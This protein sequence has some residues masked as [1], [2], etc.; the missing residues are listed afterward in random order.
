MQFLLLNAVFL[1][2]G[3]QSAN[4]FGRALPLPGS[5][6]EPAC[7]GDDCFSREYPT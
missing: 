7:N 4:V 6:L 5:E 1:V 3:L 2:L